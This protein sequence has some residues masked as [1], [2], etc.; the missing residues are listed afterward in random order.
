MEETTLKRWLEELAAQQPTPGGGGAAALAA[1]VAAGLIG[2]VSIYTTGTKWI[3]RRERMQSISD[4]AAV[5]R[6]E[7]LGLMQSD[8]DAFAKVGAVYAMSTVTK[9]GIVERK[10][11]IEAALE[12]A[13][14]PPTVVV[15]LCGRLLDLAETIA[16][17]GNPNVISDV[18][19]AA[20]QIRAAL[21]GAI[22]NIQIN[23]RLMTNEQTKQKLALAIDVA[24][25]AIKKADAIVADV[26]SRI[27][28]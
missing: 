15:N 5:L 14:K 25:D 20:S 3:D 6:A 16:P 21:E 27:A 11:A 18:A 23:A 1:A 2:M 10:A 17:D 7:A 24:E 22:V 4:E 28:S 8:A 9:D 12:G 19:V 26:R 13:A